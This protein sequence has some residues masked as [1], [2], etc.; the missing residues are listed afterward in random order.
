M[1]VKCPGPHILY[2]EHYNEKT[3]YCEYPF[4]EGENLEEVCDAFW[5]NDYEIERDEG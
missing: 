5:E 1:K 4:Q 2:C 3:G